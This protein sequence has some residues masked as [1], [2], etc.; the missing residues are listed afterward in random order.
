MRLD[1]KGK[2]P[3]AFLSSRHRL[4]HETFVFVFFGHH[5]IRWGDHH[6][7]LRIAVKD[8]RYGISQTGCCI[9]SCRLAENI[10]F[11]QIR[12]L[13]AHQILVLI[14]GDDQHTFAWT[15]PVESSHGLLQQ[16]LARTQDIMELLG[17]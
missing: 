6:D 14:G 13:L 1:A 3:V 11:R 4:A 5:R 2:E 10:L 15:D 17:I 16:A 9:P 8:F 7:R 12:K